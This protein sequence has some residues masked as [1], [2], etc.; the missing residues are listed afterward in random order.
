MTRVDLP[1][2]EA[3]A[4]IESSLGGSA[5]LKSSMNHHIR[6]GETMGDNEQDAVRLAIKKVIET[7]K[8]EELPKLSAGGKAT[9]MAMIE[10]LYIT[11]DAGVEQQMQAIRVLNSV[12]DR[13]V[14]AFN[15]NTSS[16]TWIDPMTLNL[17]SLGEKQ[18][19][20]AKN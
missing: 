12:V 8:R 19:G 6:L 15:Q 18:D 13:F 4:R 17:V 10:A 7:V 16:T 2:P 5:E 14:Q 11:L 1:A 9:F 20:P 3:P